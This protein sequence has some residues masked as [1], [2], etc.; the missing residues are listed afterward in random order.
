M[1]YMMNNML[2]AMYSYVYFEE[3]ANMGL[4]VLVACANI[5]LVCEIALLTSQGPL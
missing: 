5:E 1:A 4:V 3:I 2:Q